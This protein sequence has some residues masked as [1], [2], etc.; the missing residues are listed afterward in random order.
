MMTIP[1]LCEKLLITE[2]QLYR[3]YKAYGIQPR[4]RRGVTVFT[5]EEV[6][7]L[8]MDAAYMSREAL[9]MYIG[10]PQKELILSDD[11]QEINGTKL[12]NVADTIERTPKPDTSVVTAKSLMALFH[13]PYYRV[14]R[15]IPP[16]KRA[17]KD[18]VYDESVI[19]DV[20]QYFETYATVSDICETYPVAQRKLLK[21]IQEAGIEPAATGRVNEYIREEVE[22]LL[23]AYAF[24]RDEETQ[25]R[26]ASSQYK[27]V[28]TPDEAIRLAV[29]DMHRHYAVPR[30]IEVIEEYLRTEVKQLRSRNLLKTTKNLVADCYNCLDFLDDELCTYG[31]EAINE[32]IDMLPTETSKLRL[33]R[34]VTFMVEAG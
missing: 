3:R 7:M 5:D 20:K 24:S 14:L 34:L 12:Y 28:E 23:I 26:V 22:S 2:D 13:K 8:Q 18:G 33:C 25:K 9:A 19:E 11:W 21:I 16:D 6:A 17:P 29:M 30:T 27:L 31:Y 15:A 32:L 4:K 10:C 1:E